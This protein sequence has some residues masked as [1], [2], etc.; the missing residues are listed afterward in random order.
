MRRAGQLL[1][2]IRR[3]S[4]AHVLARRGSPLHDGWPAVCGAR[5]RRELRRVAGQCVRQP[6]QGR[7]VAAARHCASGAGYCVRSATRR[8]CPTDADTS[9]INGIAVPG[10]GKGGATARR[11][12]HSYRIDNTGH[13]IVLPAVATFARSLPARGVI[14]TGVDVDTPSA[15]STCPRIPGHAQ[16]HGANHGYFFVIPTQS[17]TAGPCGRA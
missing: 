1:A 12:N 8:C 2:P 6:S 15:P 3:C 13:G 17:W 10:A 7:C 16:P 5:V 11:R 9:R 4:A 14:P